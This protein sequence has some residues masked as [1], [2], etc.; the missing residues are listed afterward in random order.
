MEKKKYYVNV[1]TGEISQ[2][3]YDDNDDFIIHATKDEVAQLRS[4]LNHLHDA[5][6]GTFIRAHIPI[7]PY[8]NDKSNDDY[9]RNITEAFQMLYNCGDEQTKSHIVE[10]G[11]LT[12]NHM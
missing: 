1:G 9:D 5:S 7:M 11:V 8:H 12:D 6:F 2:I 4:K 3:S 10:M